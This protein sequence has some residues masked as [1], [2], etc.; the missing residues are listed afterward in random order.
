MTAGRDMTAVEVDAANLLAAG[1]PI[2]P[3]ASVTAR[4]APGRHLVQLCSRGQDSTFRPRSDAYIALG[5][6]LNRA[7]GAALASDP[8]S[9]RV[10][11][12]GR[13]VRWAAGVAGH[14]RST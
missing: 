3:R 4:Q 8:A 9:V 1:W 6:Q 10:R 14:A 11:W 7:S 13:V 5:H 12:R 2:G